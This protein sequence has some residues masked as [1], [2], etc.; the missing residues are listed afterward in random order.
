MH[1]VEPEKIAATTAPVGTD[2]LSSPGERSAAA[3][4]REAAPAMGGTN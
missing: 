3:Q 2:A 4:A 1:L